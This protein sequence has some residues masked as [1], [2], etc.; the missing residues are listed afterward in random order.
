MR[1][2]VFAVRYLNTA[3]APP[4]FPGCSCSPYIVYIWTIRFFFFSFLRERILPLSPL[5]LSLP[6]SLVHKKKERKCE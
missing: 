4:D 2:G 3:A 5:V 6:P 1:R